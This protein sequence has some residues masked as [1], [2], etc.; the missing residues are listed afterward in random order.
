[1][2]YATAEASTPRNSS[3]PS[4]GSAVDG[5]PL[6]LAEPEA[7][8]VDQQRAEQHRPPGE[9]NVGEGR[10][11]GAEP[12]AADRDRDYP[13]RDESDADRDATGEVRGVRL[14]DEPDADES[15]HY[16][17]PTARV[18]IGAADPGGRDRRGRDGNEAVGDRGDPARRVLLTDEQQGVVRR[19]R[20]RR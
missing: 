9:R 8:S 6:G 4:A 16:A 19:Q 13:D 12:D 17:E 11:H 5:E 20:V 10:L 14:G 2:T 15:Q 18:E 1:M 7:E 3:A